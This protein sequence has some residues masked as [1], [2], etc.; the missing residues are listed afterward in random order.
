VTRARS[1]HARA[2]ALVLIVLVA[3]GAVAF[4]E[5]VIG[6]WSGRAH[7]SNVVATPSSPPAAAPVAAHPRLRRS[8]DQAGAV[9][10]AGRPSTSAPRPHTPAQARTV[11]S[12]VT[13]TAVLR[14]PERHAH[15]QVAPAVVARPSAPKSVQVVTVGV[16]KALPPTDTVSWRVEPSGRTDVLSP[17]SGVLPPAPDSDR[18]VVIV[19]RIPA[20]TPA[21]AVRVATAEFDGSAASVDVPVLLTVT[22]VRRAEV[23]LVRSMYAA[24]AGDRI[25]VDVQVVNRGNA[26]DTLALQAVLPRGW[27][28]AGRPRTVVL[29]PGQQR[30]ETLQVEVPRD[31]GATRSFIQVA[32]RADTTQLAGAIADVEVLDRTPAGRNGPVLTAAMANAVGDSLG[33]TPVVSLDLYGS[34]D[35]HTLVSGHL[36][37]ALDPNDVNNQALGRVG[38]YLGQAYLSAGSSHWQA[39][40]GAAGRQF[41][42]ATGS[43]AFGVGFSGSVDV[44]QWHTALL[45]AAPAGGASGQLLGGEVGYRTASGT[46]TAH[47]TDFQENGTFTRDLRAAGLSFQSTP[48]LGARLLADAAWRDYSAGSGFGWALGADRQTRHDYFSVQAIHTPG[49]TAAYATATDQLTAVGSRQL[50]ERVAV[51]GGYA[52]SN[53]Q[54]ATFS[55]LAT[56]SLSAGSSF[57]VTPISTL[58]FDVTSTSFTANGALLGL[59]SKDVSGRASYRT[60]IRRFDTELSLTAGQ[61]QRTRTFSGITATDPWATRATLAGALGWQTGRGR[62]SASASYGYAGTGSGYL[63]NALQVGVAASGLAI[64]HN[65][66]IPTLQASVQRFEWFGARSGATV[67]RVGTL[68]PIGDAYRLTVDVERN[69]FLHPDRAGVPIV[70]AI[71]LERS[72]VLPFSHRS[73]AERGY[74]FEDLNGNGARDPQE[75]AMEGVVVRRGGDV[76]VTDKNGEFRYYTKSPNPVAVDA[77]SLAMGVVPG[78]VTPA[79]A[80]GPVNLAVV[81]TGSLEIDVVPTADQLGRL[82]TSKDLSP[83]IVVATDDRG[84]QWT[85]QADTAGHARLDALPPGRYTITADLSGLSERLRVIGAPPVVAIKAGEPLPA[86]RIPVGPNPVKMFNAVPGKP[87]SLA[88]ERK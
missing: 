65:P 32:A 26:P 30:N 35:E 15:V 13:P 83:V 17:G 41:S 85:A 75:P 3:I 34:Y 58:S 8:A 50:S 53:D 73:V 43:G 14:A 78:Q 38:M 68:I 2:I 36:A 81:P 82:P 64:S 18:N 84:T 33:R 19:T 71:K 56:Q 37:R 66:K 10:L 44:Q 12:P 77:T 62:F 49:G 51:H 74:V 52:S 22:R 42:P 23:R 48:I 69:P 25:N 9:E 60:R 59:G 88:R 70:A 47:A 76:A 16:P 27:K 61:V 28:V 57:L 67:M 24:H 31:I 79:S 5:L 54:N 72:L 20:G 80:Q 86:V 55:R 63:P 1:R 6:R 45:A 40:V 7:R 46:V 11:G 4:A 29:R 21:G 87:S 39:T